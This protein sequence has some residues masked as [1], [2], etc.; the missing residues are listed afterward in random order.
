VKRTRIVV[1]SALFVSVLAGGQASAAAQAPPVAPTGVVEPAACSTGNRSISG[2][3]RGE[4]GRFVSAQV[5]FELFDA[6]G[7]LVNMDGCPRT[8]PAY[9]ATRLVNPAPPPLDQ[10]ELLLPGTGAISSPVTIDGRS[11]GLSDTWSLSG[12]PNNVAEIWIET[13]TKRSGGQPNSTTER[14]GHSIRRVPLN[15]SGATTGVQVTQP[16][17]CGLTGGGRTGRTGGLTGR[18]FLDGRQVTPDRVDVFST[19]PEDGNGGTFLSFNTITSHPAGRYFVDAISPGTY[20]VFVTEAGITR[21]FDGLRVGAC[22]TSTVDLAVRGTVPRP[23]AVAPVVGDWDGDGGADVGVFDIGSRTWLLRN[24]ASGGGVERRFAFGASGDIPVVGDWNGDGVDGIGVFRPSTRQWFLRE[25]A[26]PGGA[27]RT[28]T[29]GGAGDQPVVGDWNGDGVDGIGV[30]R[31]SNRQWLLRET[32][33]GGSAQRSAGFGTAGD[34][35]VVGDW[36][37][38]GVD[39]IGVFRPSTRQWFL[40]QTASGGPS[41]G[42]FSYGTTGDLPVVGDWDA[43]GSSGVGVFRPSSASWLL[44]QAATGGT[45]NLQFTYRGGL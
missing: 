17:R 34:R 9:P 36:N 41:Q 1:A 2:T 10:L 30:F 3:V 29:Y 33:S 26:T 23:P 44:R 27:Q 15:P 31:P 38:D 28:V 6:Q 42:S 8:S 19:S 25:T 13:Y 21:R 35:P 5:S 32:A 22:T 16:L 45:P 11:Y 14:F 7:R 24:S 18:V 4:D 20:A 39:G 37:G 43:N 40:R 12:I